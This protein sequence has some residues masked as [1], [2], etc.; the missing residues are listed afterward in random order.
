V[1]AERTGLGRAFIGLLLLATATSLPALRWGLTAESVPAPSGRRARLPRSPPLAGVE[2]L[3]RGRTPHMIGK[4]KRKRIG[5]G[6]MGTPA[7]GPP[8]LHKPAQRGSGRLARAINATRKD[9]AL[10]PRDETATAPSPDRGGK[11][12]T[13]TAPAGTKAARSTAKAAAPP[14]RPNSSGSKRSGPSSSPAASGAKKAAATGLSPN[15]AGQ[16][17]A[18]SA[19]KRSRTKQAG[20]DGRRLGHVSA[21]GKRAQARRDSKE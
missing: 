3:K 7:M 1:I 18:E 5:Y 10:S 21:R 14:Q 16:K 12:A 2:R 4:K 6:P 15:R 19:A 17:R 20:L 9:A 11:A 8:T 13:K